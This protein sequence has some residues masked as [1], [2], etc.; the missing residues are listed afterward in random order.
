[1]KTI[2]I[3]IGVLLLTATSNMFAQ[4]APNYNFYLY[5]M[6]IYIPAFVD[7]S[8]AAEFSF[9]IRSQWAGI[10]GAP[11][12]QSTI[13]GMPIGKNVGLGVSIPND[14]DFIEQKTWVF[15]DVSYNIQLDEEHILYF[16]IKGS[17][18]SYDAHPQGLVAYGVGQ[19]GALMDY[20]SRFTP[21]VG[22]GVYL[23]HDRY[24]ASLSAPK[25][26]TPERLE[27]RDGNA[28]CGV[29]QIHAYLNNLH[30]LIII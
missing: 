16:G 14:M 1:M 20:E 12:R 17:A 7:S 25:L 13:F 21:N 11:E 3:T 29:D 6:N 10:E 24:F 23:K 4:Q 27:Q 9:G 15:I 28:Y 22:T 18:N 19:D 30:A 8:G 5:D 26:L 2:L